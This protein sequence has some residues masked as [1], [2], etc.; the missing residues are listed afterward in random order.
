MTVLFGTSINP[1]CISA[2]NIG[3]SDFILNL[4]SSFEANIVDNPRLF[5]ID[6]VLPRNPVL[7]LYSS[8]KLLRSLN[9]S[10]ISFGKASFSILPDSISIILPLKSERA[11]PIAVDVTID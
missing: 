4:G 11:N 7:Y 10:D 2:L 5:I 9:V 6:G 3:E 1:P 8:L